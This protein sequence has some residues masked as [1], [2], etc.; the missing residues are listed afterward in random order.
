MFFQAYRNGKDNYYVQN[1]QVKVNPAPYRVNISNRFCRVQAIVN[2]PN[3]SAGRRLLPAGIAWRGHDTFNF[4]TGDIEYKQTGEMTNQY[5]FPTQ[6]EAE[7][8]RYFLNGLVETFA[9]VKYTREGTDVHSMDMPSQAKMPELFK[10]AMKSRDNNST[11]EGLKDK[12]YFTVH[13]AGEWAR[14]WHS[15]IQPYLARECWDW[16]AASACSAI[17]QTAASIL[18]LNC[19]DEYETPELAEMCLS[20]WLVVENLEGS[21]RGHPNNV[22]V[23]YFAAEELYNQEFMARSWGEGVQK[24]FKELCDVDQMP[25]RST[26]ADAVATLHGAQLVSAECKASGDLE[27]AGEDNQAI[28]MC[29][30][31][32]WTDSEMSIGL[33]AQPTCFRIQILRYNRDNQDHQ[34]I[35]REVRKSTDFDIARAMAEPN[36][37]PPCPMIVYRTEDNKQTNKQLRCQPIDKWEL[38]NGY[39]QAYIRAVFDMVFYMRENL[40]KMELHS[41]DFRTTVRAGIKTRFEEPGGEMPSRIPQAPPIPPAL[42]DALYLDKRFPHRDGV[43]PVAMVMTPPKP[44]KL[45]ECG[46]AAP[47]AADRPFLQTPAPEVAVPNNVARKWLGSADLQ[48]ALADASTELRKAIGDLSV[49]ADQIRQNLADASQRIAQDED[50]AAAA[51]ARASAPA[52]R[53]PQHPPTW[54]L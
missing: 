40:E 22:Y 38:L 11:L 6:E 42:Q 34:A 43:P 9:M 12:N 25:T 47:R 3:L 51:Q 45:E 28:V 29:S 20:D 26:T 8:A 17:I 44:K 5:R 33:H 46:M 50:A 23:S 10:L 31:F 4:L 24:T 14:T 52:A 21:P 30:T 36:P 18:H 19:V 39:A 54:K 7:V 37:R 15:L 53:V 13:P 2:D 41:P 48:G 49:S 32:A 27:F 16:H 35:A 1:G